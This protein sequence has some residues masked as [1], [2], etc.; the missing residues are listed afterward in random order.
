MTE[1]DKLSKAEARW[2]EEND[3]IARRVG[4]LSDDESSWQ[5]TAKAEWLQLD[6]DAIATFARGFHA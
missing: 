1:L 4:F 2:A 3:L 6:E 5:I